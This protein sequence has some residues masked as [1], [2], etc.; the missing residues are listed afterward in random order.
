MSC[1][2]EA[3][4]C[5][6]WDIK[7]G[8]LA[9]SNN[10]IRHLTSPI[11]SYIQIIKIHFCIPSSSYKFS[12]SLK[13][14]VWKYEVVKNFV[15]IY[16]LIRIEEKSRTNLQALHTASSAF[17][18]TQKDL[19]SFFTTLRMTCVVLILQPGGAILSQLQSCL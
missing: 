6:Q 2:P 13:L 18:N 15:C 11:F 8:Y 12:L 1:I 7:S 16:L 19:L 3:M 14:N 10:L 4:K 9:A 5:L 17:L